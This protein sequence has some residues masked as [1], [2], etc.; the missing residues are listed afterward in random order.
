MSDSPSSI[1]ILP[2]RLQR[3]CVGCRTLFTPNPR[4]GDRQKTCGKSI[5]RKTHRAA[6]RRAY[7]KKNIQSERDIEK[8]RKESRGPDFWKNYRRDHP[9]STARNQANSMLKKRLLKAGL[10]RQLDIVQ[11]VDPPEKLN[12][13]T[14]FATSHRWLLCK[15]LL[16]TAA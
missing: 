14:E 13:L 1:L 4:V 3:H 11:L 15:C 10:Q 12:S 16:K 8:K 5:C 7:R 6:F 9:E 2:S